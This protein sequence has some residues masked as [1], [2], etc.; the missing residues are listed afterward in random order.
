MFSHIYMPF[1]PNRAEELIQYNHI[2]HTAAQIFAW[3]NVYR[4]DREFRTH[5]SRHHLNRSWGVILQQAWSMF[6]KDKIDRTG[7]D[8]RGSSGGGTRRK[9]CSDYN[10]GNC[11]FGKKC[12]F[13]HRCSFCNKFGHGAYNCHRAAATNKQGQ[14]S[15]ANH[16]NPKQQHYSQ[17][18]NKGEDTVNDKDRWERYEAK[19]AN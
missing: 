13:D 11:T 7:Q 4:Y 5:M 10:S 16:H 8:Q 6:L 2:I 3:E 9:L 19:K 1:H 14:H 17:H 15:G 12:C 18:H